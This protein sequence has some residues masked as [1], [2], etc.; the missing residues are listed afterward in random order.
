MT[1]TNHRA[2]A[3]AFSNLAELSPQLYDFWLSELYDLDGEP[4]WSAWSNYNLRLMESD[5]T[6]IL[7]SLS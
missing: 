5:I 4:L 7:S 3:L 1:D 6:N 2:I